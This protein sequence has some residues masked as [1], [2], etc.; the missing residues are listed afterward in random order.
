MSRTV[1]R[2]VLITVLGWIGILGAALG[3]LHA[4]SPQS[5]SSA[6]APAVPVSTVIN[7]YCLACHNDKL[8]TADLSL[9]QVK[10]ESVSPDAAMWEKVLVKLRGRAMPPAGVP[11]PDNAGYE[12]CI[13]YLERELDRSAAAKPNPGR[14]T[15]HR[16][17]RAEYTNAIRDLLAID[18]DAASLL[19]IDDASYGFDNIGDALTVSPTLLER[20]LSAAEKIS[21]LA[22]GDPNI[23]PVSQTYRVPSDFVQDDRSSERLPFESRGGIAIR[24]YFPLDGE[25]L[26]QIRLQRVS[27]PER[28]GGVIIGL[29]EP[30]QIDLR[31]DGARVKRFTVGGEG[32][33]YG[34]KNDS[35]AHDETYELH[36]DEGLEL[37]LPVNAGS[38][39]IGVA[40]LNRSVEPEDA[41]QRYDGLPQFG[42]Q[43]EEEDDLPAVDHVTIAGPYSRQGSGDTLSRRRIFVCRPIDGKEENNCAREILATLA[44]RAYRRPVTDADVQTLLVFY[45]SGR[46]Q[47]DFEAGIEVALKAMLVS[48]QFLF[49]IERDPASVAPGAAYRV[50]DIELASRLSFFL[51]SS[52]PDDELLDAAERGKLHDPAILEQQVRRM[53]ADSRSRALVS[54]FA[55]QWLYVRNIQK[56]VPDRDAFPEFDGNLREA[57]QQETEL[58]FESMLREDR[59]VLDLLNA[60]YTFLNERLARHY[61]IPN[62]Y[63][64]HFRRVTL[65]DENRKGLVGQGSILTVTSYAN[66]TSPT[67]RGK[68]LLEN[69]LGSP[70][71]PPPNNVPSLKDRGDDGKILSVRQQMEQHRKDP[72]C[73]GCHTRMDPLGFALENFDAIG[74]WRTTS[75]ADRTPIDSSGILPDGT[76]FNGPADLRKVLLDRPEEFVTTVS[77]KLLTYALGRGTE[78]YDAPAIRKI[79]REAAPGGYRWSSLIL[80]VAQSMPFQMRRSREP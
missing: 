32:R 44:R 6:P 55:G 58:F 15:I 77:E 12:S 67:L 41:L 8:K 78:Y 40:F 72:A 27:G 3:C 62:I 17:N 45:K 49:R 48:P 30:H 4:A 25:Y 74:R 20:Y 33:D 9:S 47:R 80:G 28:N 60:D 29:A 53:L 69:I 68:W 19:P 35:E 7:R 16:L 38:H 43:Y 57:F 13:A 76:H 42:R 73:A 70:P 66:R 51:W 64:S 14:P 34:K 31:L 1:P 39:R 46:K 50:S 36:A 75:G 79:V 24:H 21:R 56:V 52:I 10:L 18:I 11:R 61:G 63:G 26:I 59:S 37:R 23:S 54:N 5:S 71:P 22:I 65:S 2:T